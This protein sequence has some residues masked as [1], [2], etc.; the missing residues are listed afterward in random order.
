MSEDT[1][2]CGDAADVLASWPD[3]CVDCCV[4]SPPYYGLRDYGAEGQIGLEPTP[5]EYIARQAP[6]RIDEIADLEME[7]KQG[8]MSAFFGP[9]KIPAPA[10]T[11]GEKYPTIRDVVRYVEWQNATGSLFDDDTATSCMSYYGLCE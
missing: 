1:I 9:D 10:I 6:E 3:G 8:V 11:S 5:E 4:T 7:L 2:Y